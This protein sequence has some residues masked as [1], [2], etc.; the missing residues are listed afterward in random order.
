MDFPMLLLLLGGAALLAL[1]GE[2]LVRGSVALAAR[3]GVSPL[4]AGLTIVAF[5]TS[6]PELVTSVIAALAGSP[7]IAI[8]NVVGS[9]MA[10]ILLIVGATALLMPIAVDRLAYRRDA[11]MLV[12]ATG[13]TVAVMVSLGRVDRLI[14]AGFL[15]LLAVHILWAYFGE[16]RRTATPPDSGEAATAAPDY[17]VVPALLLAI[18]GMAATVGGARL[19]VDG[20]IEL[21]REFGMSEAVIGLTIVAVG[22][23]LPELVTSVVAALRKHS[24]VALGNVIG[25][26]LFN[27]LGILGVTA[28]VQPLSVPASMIR[29]DGWALAAATLLLVALLLLVRRIGRK[30]GLAML[31]AYAGYIA[32][33]SQI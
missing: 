10:N 9:N 30:I 19:L 4:L 22:T 21:A 27:L 14:G 3:L 26:S 23:S 16:R 1:G 11:F 24:E 5:G 18:L 2:L 32:L 28:L 8:G 31:L 29:F 17:A 7:D 6:A 33:L 25:S 15:A 12:V 13:A 20:A